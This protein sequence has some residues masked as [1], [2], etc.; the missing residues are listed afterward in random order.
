MADFSKLGSRL[1]FAKE[2]RYSQ[3]HFLWNMLEA[4]L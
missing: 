1:F 4:N 2:E 3:G